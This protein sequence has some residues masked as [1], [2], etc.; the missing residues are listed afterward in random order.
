MPTY[1]CRNPKDSRGVD[2]DWERELDN[3]ITSDGQL[4]RQ[5]HQPILRNL[6]IKK[7][8]GIY[9]H[10]LAVKLMRHLVDN[11][12]KKYVREHATPG[13]ERLV[14]VATKNAV[15]KLFVDSFETEYDL[16]NYDNFLPKKYQG[17]AHQ[18]PQLIPKS[19]KQVQVRR[20]ADGRVQVK[21]RNPSPSVWQRAFLGRGKK[22]YAV[23]LY[24]QQEGPLYTS[25]AAAQK[26]ASKFNRED[27]KSARVIKWDPRY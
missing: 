13:D 10:E 14:S 21:I 25:K 23:L 7:A 1:R 11:G 18:N 9:K 24:G 19:W 4:Y 2:E 5:Q 20:L 12:L 17:R 6:A 16:G 15:A 3:Y 26:V 27:P 8:R 22:Q